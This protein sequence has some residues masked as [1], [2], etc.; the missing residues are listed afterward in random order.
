MS[1]NTHEE[2]HNGDWQKCQEQTCVSAKQWIKNFRKDDKVWVTA[3][4][5]VILIKDMEDAHL[6]NAY[7]YVRKKVSAAVI[8]AKRMGIDDVKASEIIE[9]EF[10]VLNDLKAEML[11]RKSIDLKVYEGIRNLDL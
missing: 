7:N 9:S 8:I 10:P 4:K 11:R 1:Q 3:D 6:H 5:R 2:Y